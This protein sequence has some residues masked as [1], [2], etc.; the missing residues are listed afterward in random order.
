MVRPTVA[1]F[2]RIQYVLRRISGESRYTDLGNALK[3][4]PHP[5]AEE[6]DHIA[7]AVP[8]VYISDENNRTQ[9]GA[10]A[11]TNTHNV[12][13]AKRILMVASFLNRVID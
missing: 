11:L 13:T 8:D 5:E 3:R 6:G 4:N 12:A 10:S 2:A 9:L 7:G 1:G